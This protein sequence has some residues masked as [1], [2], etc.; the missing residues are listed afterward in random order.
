[1]PTLIPQNRRIYH[2]WNVWDMR[3]IA[4]EVS[5]AKP[6]RSNSSATI[7]TARDP[8][9]TQ[10]K[11]TMDHNRKQLASNMF[12]FVGLRWCPCSYFE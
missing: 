10:H 3:N 9:F 5:P 1:M 11:S 8:P 2:A 4:T 12:L 6:P 7:A